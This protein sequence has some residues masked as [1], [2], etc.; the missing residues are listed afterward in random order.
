MSFSTKLLIIIATRPFLGNKNLQLSAGFLTQM[1]DSYPNLSA[2]KALRLMNLIFFAEWHTRLHFSITR[3]CS[4]QS[5]WVLVI[6][7]HGPENVTFLGRE[8]QPASHFLHIA[9]NRAIINHVVE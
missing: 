4:N 9:C 6:S 3:F 8:R 1:L 2:N 5:K 7:V